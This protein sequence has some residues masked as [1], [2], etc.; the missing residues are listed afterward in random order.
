MSSY[1]LIAGAQNPYA[2]Q[3]FLFDPGPPP[4]PTLQDVIDDI[5]SGVLT[6]LQEIVAR[7]EELL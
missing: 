1:S 7:L 2:S 6:D 4:P 5:N 3:W